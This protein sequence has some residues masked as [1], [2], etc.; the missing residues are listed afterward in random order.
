MLQ[1]V[2]AKALEVLEP[3]ACMPRETNEH[4][5]MNSA[6]AQSSPETDSVQL[7]QLHPFLPGRVYCTVQVL[8]CAYVPVPPLFDLREQPGLDEGTTS[9][10]GCSQPRALLQVPAWDCRKECTLTS[11]AA[12]VGPLQWLCESQQLPLTASPPFPLKR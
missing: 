4:I 8:A 3:L 2:G 1:T 6:G 12:T 11:A 9:N 5:C 7:H 10:V